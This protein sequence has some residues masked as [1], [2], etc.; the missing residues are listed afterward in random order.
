MTPQAPR[1]VIISASIG[2]GHDGAAAELAHRLGGAGCAVDRYDFVDLL[3]ARLGVALRSAYRAQLIS[4]PRTWGWLLGRAGGPGF[5]R[6]AATLTAPADRATAAVVNGCQLVVSTYPLASQVLGRLR[7]TNRLGVP[8]VTYLTDLSVHRLWIADGV[9]IHLALHDDTAR[10]AKVLGAVDVR[11]VAPAVPSRFTVPHPGDAPA[12]ARFG[13]PPQRPLAL[14]VA[15]SWGVGAVPDAAREIAATGHALPVVACGHNDRLRRRILRD[16]FAHALGWVSDMPALLACC[17]VVVQNAGGLS[18]LEALTAA[19]PVV[20]YRCV[21]GHGRDNAE[22]LDRIGW[23]PWLRTRT[24]LTQGLPRAMAGT[25]GLTPAAVAPETPL[26][27]L[28]D[29]AAA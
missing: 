5:A 23:V 17:Q 22:A 27:D 11:V 9:D 24:D 4:A 15:G 18:S 26:L 3:P 29:A 12:R 21:P 8:A 16:G 6:R 1:V 2:A 25:G 20:S 7:R 19:R 10:H 14:V 28:V 13:L